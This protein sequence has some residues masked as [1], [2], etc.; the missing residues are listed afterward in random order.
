MAYS[1]EI[2]NV[3]KKYGKTIALEDITFN[4]EKSSLFGLIGPDGSGKTTLIKMIASLLIQDRGI[5]KVENFD[6]IHDYKKIRK[7]IGYMPGKFSLYSDLTV[8]ENLKLFAVIFNSDINK[9]YDLIKDIYSHLEP[10]KKRL[11]GHL[12]G[13]MK[14]KLALSAALIHKPKILLLDEPT[15][16]ID[17]VSRRDL[18]Q[19]L[20]KLKN[21]GITV[22]VSTP[23]MDEAALCDSMAFMRNGKI[24]QINNKQEIVKDFK[25]DLFSVKGESN[26]YLLK[27]LQKFSNVINV[28]PFGENIHITCDSYYSNHDLIIQYLKNN[29]FT[30]FVVEKIEPTLEDCFISLM[31]E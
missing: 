27:S 20:K 16:G 11:A 6:N 30:D 4:I 3:Y 9:N 29:N 17:P 14:Q 18:W 28:Y 2:N 21:F 7:I 8:E 13:G 1:V 19:M 31:N 23:F 15:T 12:S 22:I 10:Y 25:Q 5:I 24:L 26:Y